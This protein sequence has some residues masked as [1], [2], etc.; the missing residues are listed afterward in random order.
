ML[1][2]RP[3]TVFDCLGCGEFPEVAGIVNLRSGSAG[4]CAGPPTKDHGHGGEHY[5]PRN[6]ILPLPHGVV[7]RS[8]H[9][10]PP[11]GRLVG[12]NMLSADFL[13]GSGPT[14]QDFSRF[15]FMLGHGHPNGGGHFRGPWPRNLAKVALSGCCLC[16]L[17]TPETTRGGH[18]APA[19]RAGPG[20]SALAGG[21]SGSRGYFLGASRDAAGDSSMKV[22]MK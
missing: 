22:E 17:K 18:L 20:V 5:S 15:S 21:K 8:G 7:G 6:S 14:T 10:G 11:G 4:L 12:P 3:Q 13:D 9:T 2:L 16:R 19:Q 1:F